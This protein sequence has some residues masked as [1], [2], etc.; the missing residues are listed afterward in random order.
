MHHALCAERQLML[1]LW[2]WLLLLLRFLLHVKLSMMLLVMRLR[3]LVW[4]MRRRR[5]RGGRWR[6]EPALPH[7]ISAPLGV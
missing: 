6:G 7:D 3:W 2:W 5:M 4:V 1:M